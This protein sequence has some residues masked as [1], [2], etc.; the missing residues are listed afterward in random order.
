ME[1]QYGE[2]KIRYNE[3]RERFECY[4][5][6]HIYYSVRLTDLKK[7]LDKLGEN[8]KEFKKKFDRIDIIKSNYG[9]DEWEE[10]QITSVAEYQYGSKEYWITIKGKR[11]KETL[12]FVYLNNT[13][14]QRIVNEIKELKANIQQIEDQIEQ[15]I[16]SMEKPVIEG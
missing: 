13:Y 3:S 6:E 8:E 11:Q 12:T 4:L 16:E 2:Y 7:K 5:G 15:K 1:E 9:H 10:G 14:N